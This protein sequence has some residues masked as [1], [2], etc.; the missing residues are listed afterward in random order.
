MNVDQPE[1]E[2]PPPEAE[3]LLEARQQAR[4]DK[5]WAESDRLRDEIAV[6]GWQVQDTPEGQ[7]LVRA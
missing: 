7:K 6:L 1:V 2:V 3:K 4:A 5:N